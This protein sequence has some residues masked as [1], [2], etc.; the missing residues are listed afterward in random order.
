MS[1][2]SESEDRAAD[3]IRPL[4]TIREAR[5]MLGGI[6]ETR[7]YELVHEGQLELVKLGRLS[8]VTTA[9][10]RRFI[11]SL[12]SAALQRKTRKAG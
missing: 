2:A 9:S 11:E 4:Q 10:I 5:A 3:T 1:L 7:F 12:P 8:R 6:G